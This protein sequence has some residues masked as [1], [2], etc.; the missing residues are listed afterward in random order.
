MAGVN[1]IL[2]S[3]GESNFQDNKPS[4]YLLNV[5]VLNDLKRAIR[6]AKG[7]KLLAARAGQK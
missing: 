3:R 5:E 1:V 4:S 2:V 7:T 6:E